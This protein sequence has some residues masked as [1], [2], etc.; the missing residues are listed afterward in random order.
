MIG[1]PSDAI[2]AIADGLEAGGITMSSS[3][4]GISGLRGVDSQTARRCTEA[5]SA[6]DGRVAGQDAALALR[7]ALGLREAERL[8]RPEIEI[9]WTGPEARGP[10]VRPTAV[11]IEEML[12]GVRDA[13]EVLIIGYSLTAGPQSGMTK[14]IELLNAASRKRAVV[15]CILHRDEDEQNRANLLGAW[16]ADAV[17]PRLLTWDPPPDFPYTKLHAKAVVVDRLEALVTSANLT[18]HGLQSNLELGLRVRGPQAQAIALRFD[19]LI[20]SNVLKEWSDDY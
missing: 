15:T 12:K 13:G 9:V 1:S 18:A 11:V 8:E 5:F 14:I 4:V 3:A 7:V 19:H 20:A 10:L 6:L 16:D 17:K 2:E